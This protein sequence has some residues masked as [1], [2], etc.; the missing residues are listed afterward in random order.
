MVVGDLGDSHVVLAERNSD[1]KGDWRAKCLSVAQKPWE[2]GER[3]RIHE[4]G[5]KLNRVYGETRLGGYHASR[6]RLPLFSQLTECSTGALNMSRSLGDMDYKQPA[7]S[8]ITSS[9]VIREDLP[10]KEGSI[11]GDLVS[12]E[13]HTV[14]RDLPGR[15]L[16]LLATDGVGEGPAA[17]RVAKQAA[18]MWEKKMSAQ[19]IAEQL[20]RK[21]EKQR[22]ADNC[23]IIVVCMKN[24][25]RDR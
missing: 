5:G 24:A 23:T 2:K 15:C 22:Y 9:N 10:K 6:R 16:L 3:E 7:A 13:A 18:E 17:E 19:K 25:D 21:S 20:A 4:A 14:T 12:N 8:W 11:T 1:R